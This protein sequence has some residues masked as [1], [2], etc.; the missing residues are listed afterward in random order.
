M[1]KQQ[2]TTMCNS[3]TDLSEESKMIPAAVSSSVLVTHFTDTYYHMGTYYRGEQ[4]PNTKTNELLMR[5][6]ELFMHSNWIVR[7][8]GKRDRM[9]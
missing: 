1:I 2:Q 8:R 5:L 6:E 7:E 4:F 3:A 9:N